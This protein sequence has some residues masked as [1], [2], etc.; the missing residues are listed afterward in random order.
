MLPNSVVGIWLSH[1]RIDR[2]MLRP[3]LD[4]D[5]NIT[6]GC[7]R[8]QVHIRSADQGYVD[9]FSR[10]GLDDQLGNIPRLF[11]LHQFSLPCC[12]YLTRSYMQGG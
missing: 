6:P 1:A 10:K 8:H 3:V 9:A 4:S 5:F 7:A 12:I 2:E 11:G